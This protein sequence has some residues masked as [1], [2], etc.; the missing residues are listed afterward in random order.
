MSGLFGI[1]RRDG[2]GLE[3][4]VLEA[5]CRGMSNW[6]PDG[7]AIWRDGPA[8][9]GQARLSST[10]QSRLERLP[11]ADKNQGMV[12]TAAARVDNREELGQLLGIPSPDHDGLPDS[13]FLWRAYLRWGE[14]CPARVFGDWAFAVWHPA[15]R[16]LFLARDHFGNTSL[17]YCATPQVFA[18]ASNR[19]PLLDL[20]LVPI[21]LDELY[22]AQVL[23]S[24]TAY[25]SE[26][27]IHKPIRR[28]PP[29]HSI[30]VKPDA[31]DVR[32]YW[33]LED[34]P[35]LHLPGRAQYVEAFTEVF[36]E[37]VRCRLRTDLE[38]PIAVTLSG[39]LDSGAIGA[40]AALQLRQSGQRLLAFT[41]VPL[42]DTQSYV[43]DRFG[44]EF[45]L[46]ECTARFAGNVD[47]HAIATNTLTP[48]EAIR[49]M[50]QIQ[51]EPGHSGANAYWMLELEQAARAHGCR[52]L[53]TGQ[54]GNAGI[55]W[56]GEL[57]SQPF[58]FQLGPNLG[59][60][61]KSRLRRQRRALRQI[62]PQLASKW[63]RRQLEGQQWCRLSAI[64]PDFAGRLHLLDQ[65][66]SDPREFP[67]ATPQAKRRQI[68]LPG[69][70]LAGGLHAQLGA[71]HG[72]EVRDPSADARVLAFTLSVPDHIFTDPT[73]GM[74]RWLIRAAMKG[75]LPDE[76]R[77]NRRRGRQAGD[78]V[79]RLRRCAR[80][81]ETA[82]DELQYGPAAAYL[83]VRYMRQVWKMV[84]TQ[85]TPDALRKSIT[86]LTRGI[87]AGLFVNQVNNGM[88][89]AVDRFEC[90][91]EVIS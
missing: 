13:E 37:A 40:T 22:L 20:N 33:R 76:V 17:Y 36:D 60:W 81:I 74:D 1:V 41:S 43:G 64:H 27:T 44:D 82:L 21:E 84:Q 5:L 91:M 77:L 68:L 16:K 47:L 63:L 12:F 52:V 67:S 29:A 85:D 26:R 39:G 42:G 57:S 8:G 18:F 32:Q 70:S 34:A 45:A 78:L 54:M 55:S 73:T 48:I 62:F 65:I 80:E 4:S 61:A 89:A 30:T 50:L 11:F 15:E 35:E 49:S 23:V 25:H 58:S 87:M 2:E 19:Q 66:L 71:A 86:V 46:A 75:R 88:H 79:P 10:R 28:L 83:D 6:G 69:R 9:L 59:T 31:V 53:L 38:S 3:P 7:C 24:W 51:C 14:Q 56:T 72:L 90:P